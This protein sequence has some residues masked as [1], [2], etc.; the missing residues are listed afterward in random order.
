MLDIF[1]AMYLMAMMVANITLYSD[2]DYIYP[3]E[4]ESVVAVSLHR[5]WW[6]EDGNGKCKYTGVMVPFA[7]DWEEVIKHSESFDTVL[8]P[9]PD[10]TAGY[11]FII[12]RKI[13]GDKVEAVFRSAAVI[14]FGKGFLYKHY[15]P[16]FDVTEMRP[17]Q[18]PKWMA[19]VLHRIERVSASNVEAKSFIEFNKAAALKLPVDLDALVKN[20]GTAPPAQ[21]DTLP[22][23]SVT[24]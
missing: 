14:G 15:F 3:T 11:A 2:Q 1:N 24:Q 7:R 22:H 6:R 5:E 4:R 13:C 20:L 21:E 9:E 23:P 8:P 10:K 12:N 18:Q 19:Q 17:D 16:A